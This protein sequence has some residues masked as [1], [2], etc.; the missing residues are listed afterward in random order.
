VTPPVLLV[1]A[2]PQL[3]Q[4]VARL[5]D[6]VRIAHTDAPTWRHAV[7]TG[8]RKPLDVGLPMATV[9]RILPT[10]AADFPAEPTS[11]G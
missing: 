9:R 8:L 10:P 7:A 2:D 11:R 5:L 1:L 3:R 4:R 6:D